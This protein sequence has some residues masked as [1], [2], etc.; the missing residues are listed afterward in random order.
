MFKTILKEICIILL[1]CIAILLILGIIFYE[2]V[3]INKTVPEK[4]SYTIPDE[5][6]SEMQNNEL[7]NE[8]QTESKIEN[9]ITETTVYE[10]TSK[11][12]NKYES[13]GE[14]VKGKVNPF[15]EISNQTNNVITN[16]NTNNN[17]IDNSKSSNES[18]E[19]LFNTAVGK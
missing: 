7:Q 1:L 5:I 15:E 12:L 13:T 6:E 17:T 9:L 16:D 3:P 14:Y 10:V 18:E 11:D 2:Y 19:H 4:V 8:I